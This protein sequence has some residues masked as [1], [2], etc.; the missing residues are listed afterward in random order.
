MPDLYVMTITWHTHVDDRT[1]PLCLRLDE[2]EWV[3]VNRKR[4]PSTLVFPGY[5]AVWDVHTNM[6]RTH[7]DRHR[8]GW[9]CRCYL[10]WKV[11]DS[12]LRER[13][14]EMRSTTVDPLL[15]AMLHAGAP[16]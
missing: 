7:G 2:K 12:G 15:E 11:D 16:L 13:L 8:G 1:C 3:F 14:R 6:P 10:T 9:N 5:G 4:L